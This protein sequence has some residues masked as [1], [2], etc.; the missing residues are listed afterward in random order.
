VEHGHTC[1]TKRGSVASSQL[2]R[3]MV[4]RAESPLTAA[5]AFV[6]R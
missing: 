4:R 2:D 6:E 5:Y 3:D 1:L